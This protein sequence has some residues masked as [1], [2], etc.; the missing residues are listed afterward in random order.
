M[1]KLNFL[2]LYDVV[3][4]YFFKYNNPKNLLMYRFHAAT[5]VSILLL[6]HCI[7]I[8]LCIKKYF[9]IDLIPFSV[10]SENYFINF[11]ISV[12]FSALYWFGCIHYYNPKRI[13]IISKRFPKDYQSLTIKNFLYQ[14]IFFSPLILIKIGFF[15]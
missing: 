14:F 12:P 2:K 10:L 9:N 3:F 5:V 8:Y 11:A 7:F 1:F 4:Y 13:V 15:S 6:F